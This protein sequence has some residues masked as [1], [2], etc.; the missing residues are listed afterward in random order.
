MAFAH[1][2]LFLRRERHGAQLQSGPAQINQRFLGD[3]T[4]D[5]SGRQVKNAF[6]LSSPR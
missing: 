1:T 3:G 6:E 2:D 5:R 4:S